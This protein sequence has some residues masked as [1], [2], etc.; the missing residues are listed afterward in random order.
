MSTE[1]RTLADLCDG[2]IDERLRFA[3]FEPSTAAQIANMFVS[4]AQRLKRLS[5]AAPESP[6]RAFW[7]P[8]RIEVLGKHTDYAGGCSLLGAVSKGFAVVTTACADGKCCV[9]TQFSDGRELHQ[10]LGVVTAHNFRR[11]N[12]RGVPGIEKSFR[13]QF[14]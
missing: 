14:V 12:V 1:S 3:G 11:H 13:Q 8:G 9:F 6:A 2:R 4:S 5:G 7:V 10:I